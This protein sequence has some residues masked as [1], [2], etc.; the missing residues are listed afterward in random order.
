MSKVSWEQIERLFAQAIDLPAEDREAF[1]TQACGDSADARLELLSLL[2]AHNGAAG[3]LDFQPQMQSA[4]PAESALLTEGTRLGSWQIGAMIGRGG[5]GEVYAAARVDGQYEQKVAI[6]VLRR[7][8]IG[9]AQRF[10]AERHILARLEHPGIARL[11]DGGVLQDER[12]YAVIEYVE[13]RP[14][15]EHCT[16]NGD[17]L[18][19]R[20]QLFD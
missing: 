16:V 6:K 17:G 10:L 15:I 12:P 14:L 5:A 2:R 9:E 11:L 3:P 18:L 20:L 19:R 13:G 8:S 1:V 4:G 7:E